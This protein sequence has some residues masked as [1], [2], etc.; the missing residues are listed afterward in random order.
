MGAQATLTLEIELWEPISGSLQGDDG[1]LH[2]FSGSLGL[3]SAIERARGVGEGEALT[4]TTPP[5]AG[6]DES[7]CGP[8]SARA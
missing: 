7:A 2:S 3:L 4:R 5:N 8:G 1:F 6:P